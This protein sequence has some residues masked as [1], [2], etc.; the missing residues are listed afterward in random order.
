MSREKVELVRASWDAWARGDMDGVLDTFHPAIEWDTTHFAGWPESDV[1][2][3]HDE[4]RR[5]FEEWLGTWDSYEAGL[6]DV[7][8]VED[9]VVTLCWQRGVGRESRVPVEVGW[10]QVV[11]FRDGKIAIIDNYTDR[12]E[13]LEAAG[14][15]E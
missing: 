3:G 10:A 6:E 8:E 7:I 4:V 5:F 14:L 11:A 12:P 2:R 13:A 9:R 1:Y 15:S